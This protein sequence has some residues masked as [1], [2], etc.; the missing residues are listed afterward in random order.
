MGGIR[1]AGIGLALA[2]LA[3]ASVSQ[4]LYQ[5]TGNNKPVIGET[6][7]VYLGDRML[8]QGW[9]EYRDCVTP[10]FDYQKSMNLGA[11][12]FVVRSGE[13][14][15]RRTAEAKHFTPDYVNW[16]AG[17][18][19]S[20]YDVTLAERPGGAKE[21]CLIVW[22]VKS[23]CSK[24]RTA[25][26]YDVGATFVSERNSLQQTIE[27]SGKSGSVLKFIYSEFK[28]GYAR[29]AFTRDFQV[30]LN[31]GTVVAYKGAILEIENAT[32]TQIRYKVIRNFAR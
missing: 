17:S 29:D 10:K 12:K 3:T 24:G 6:T 18:V 31:E 30:D 2:G 21:I 23:G 7:T 14:I 13:P 11:A 28:N 27:Y 19:Q 5:P 15:C 1:L 16:D 22:G 4:P 20:T 9:G 26:D 8:E 32:N 25:A